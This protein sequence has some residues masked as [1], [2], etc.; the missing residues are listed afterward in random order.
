MKSAWKKF[1]NELN[2]PVE[3]LH[4]DKFLNLHNLEGAEFP[5]AYLKNGD[6]LRLVIS[7]SEINSRKS[8]E[9]LM[10]LVKHKVEEI[11]KSKVNR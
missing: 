7:R 6:S 1:I 4:R 2:I 10:N 5:S 8:L 3:F 11:I 9:D